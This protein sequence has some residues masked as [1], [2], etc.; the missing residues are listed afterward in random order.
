MPLFSKKKKVHTQKDMII[1]DETPFAIQEAYKILRTNIMFSISEDS[2]KTIVLTSATQGE[3]KSSTAVNLA[4]TLAK[5]NLNVLLIDCDLRLPTVAQKLHIADKPGLTNYLYKEANLKLV[6]RRLSPGLYVIPAGDTPPN[7]SETLSSKSMQ[8]LL[9]SMESK[10][11]YIILDTPPVCT[12]TD[13]VILSE[14]ASGVVLVV[15]Q[16]FATYESLESALNQLK[17]AGANVLGT[18]MTGTTAVKKNYKK[19]GYGYGYDYGY[20]S[21]GKK[22][23]S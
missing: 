16:D 18:V 2:C 6:L 5:N 10:F 1:S 11:D 14:K 20:A 12:V 23:K 17:L 15:R 3:G 4:L 9:V 13:A 8:D 7:P 22:G 21:S 19:Y